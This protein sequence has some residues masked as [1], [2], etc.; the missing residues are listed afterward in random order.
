MSEL[1]KLAAH[2]RQDACET[3]PR[4]ETAEHLYGEWLDSLDRLF[5]DIERWLQP[6]IQSGAASI[7][8]RSLQINESPT[9]EL[10]RS[11]AAPALALEV[12]GR[13]T[14][15]RP[16][17]RFC[18]GCQGRVDIMARETQWF[19]TRQLEPDEAWYLHSSQRSAGRPLDADSLATVF[20]QF[21]R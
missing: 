9:P 12:N 19:L 13:S 3:P 10:S 18:L 20:A 17:A 6:L 15:I 16:L 8:R 5:V 2:R 21:Q 4:M 1:E 14:L 11:Y 7:E